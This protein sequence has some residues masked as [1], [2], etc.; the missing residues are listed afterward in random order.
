MSTWEPLRLAKATSR[1]ALR[2]IARVPQYQNCRAQLSDGLVEVAHIRP[3]CLNVRLGRLG[4]ACQLVQS[5]LVNGVD[6][7]APVRVRPQ[8]EA[9]RRLIPPPVVE[10][11]D[12][13]MILIDG[14]HRLF[15]VRLA[16]VSAVKVVLV[17]GDLPELPA[18]PVDWADVRV[19]ADTNLPREK[20]F[21]NLRPTAEGLFREMA[22]YIDGES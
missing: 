10:V 9:G 12:G 19:T 2:V 11:H 18:D 3:L 16:G 8:P 13:R 20:K 15:A 14:H 22:E 1:D 6:L 4:A 5:A 7:F 21:R 17:R